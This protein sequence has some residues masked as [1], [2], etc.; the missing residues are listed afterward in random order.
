MS[1]LGFIFTVVCGYLLLTLPR[2]WALVP[3]LIGTAY[4][5]TG[6]AIQ[7]GPASFTVIRLLVV[8]GFIRV[9]SRRERVGPHWAWP[10][11]AGRSPVVI[12]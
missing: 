10:S 11:G 6:Q 9:K 5:T 8:V 2:R 7:I 12:T 3:L 1:L 4:M